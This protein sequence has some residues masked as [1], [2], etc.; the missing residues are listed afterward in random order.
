RVVVEAGAHELVEA[1]G[2]V[3]RPLAVHLHD[4]RALRRVDLHAIDRRCAIGRDEEK[5]R[6]E[7]FHGFRLYPA[8][9]TNCAGVV[10]TRRTSCTA[11]V[12]VTLFSFPSAP[13]VTIV[14]VSLSGKPFIFV[15]A[16]D[17]SSLSIAA[18]PVRTDCPA[19]IVA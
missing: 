2:A 6:G 12:D 16:I 18:M 8:G 17:S 4:E 10:A 11:T 14:V 5:Q 9:T 15:D 1:V 7:E 19:R 3:R 13:F